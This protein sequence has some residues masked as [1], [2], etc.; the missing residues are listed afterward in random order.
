MKGNKSK[1]K[2][3]TIVIILCSFVFSGAMCGKTKPPTEAKIK[4][5]YWKVFDNKDVFNPIIEAFKEEN[6]NV[7][8]VYEKK[9][10]S[11]YK[12]DIVNALAANAGPDIISIKND[13]MPFFADKVQ[14]LD[15]KGMINQNYI[16]DTKTF[17]NTFAPVA[18]DD[19]IINNKIYGMPLSIDTLVLYYNNEIFYEAEI[20]NPPA[21]WKEFVTTVKKIKKIGKRAV[22]LGTVSNIN[23]APDIIYLLMLQRF[24]ASK[25]DLIN[26][27]KQRAIFNLPVAGPTGRPVYPGKDAIKFYTSFANPNESVYT[28]NDK[29]PQAIDAF[30][31]G[32][33]AMIFD[34]SWQQSYIEKINPDLNYEIAPVPQISKIDEPVNY[35]SY[36]AE[37][38]T[39]DCR[40]PDIAWNFI[41]FIAT[42]QIN[43][44]LQATKKPS[45]I[46]EDIKTSSDPYEYQSATAKNWYK[47]EPEKVDAIFRQLIKNIINYNQPIQR[48]LDR[49][50][51]DVTK[52]LQTPWPKVER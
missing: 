29:N 41:N 49:A 12:Q 21:T 8:I 37:T 2:I 5:V 3:L 30:A 50:A 7:D 16:M 14:P 48:S 4:L 44:Y 24:Q 46:L 39:K 27:D 10:L 31:Q 11:T 1:L 52:I 34:Y 38:V 43:S 36:W 22:A 26:A 13:W 47:K 28:W 25:A 6:P 17:K 15:E 33:V 45:P 20:D 18:A 40:Y 19:L 23:N 42:K 35:A 9:D 32:K 51:A